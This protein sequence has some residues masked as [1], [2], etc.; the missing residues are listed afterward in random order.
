MKGAD[1]KQYDIICSPNLRFGGQSTS[2]SA[3]TR[4][5]KMDLGFIRLWTLRRVSIILKEVLT[6]ALSLYFT[7]RYSCNISINHRRALGFYG[8]FFPDNTCATNPKHNVLISSCPLSATST[9]TQPVNDMSMY[10]HPQAL[11]FEPRIYLAKPSP[12]WL[13]LGR[14]AYHLSEY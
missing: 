10:P 3:R 13:Q 9:S 6:N 12:H 11:T 14:A 5:I 2:P 4:T 1:A 8:I 7:S